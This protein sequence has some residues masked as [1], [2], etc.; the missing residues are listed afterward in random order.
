M[1]CSI[2][3]VM[4]FP[5]QG[6]K[7]ASQQPGGLWN[8]RPPC[9][10]SHAGVVWKFRSH[11]ESMLAEIPWLW[12]FQSSFAHPGVLSR[13]AT[14]FPELLCTSWHAV[15]G[16]TEFPY[17]MHHAPRR[18]ER[19]LWNFHGYGH[20]TTMG[21]TQLRN[22]QRCQIPIVLECPQLRN[23]HSYGIPRDV[24]FP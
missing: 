4:E 16:A 14:E 7:A 11:G 10:G 22:F 20:A 3:H 24:R 1:Q 19:G 12:K 8:F 13:R 15:Q 5:W 6:G 21:F 9:V 23:F 17:P 2:C 18:Q